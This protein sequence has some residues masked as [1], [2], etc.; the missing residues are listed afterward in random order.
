MLTQLTVSGFGCI[1][2]PIR[3]D[4]SPLG[5][6]AEHPA[7]DDHGL[8]VLPIAFLIDQN[9]HVSED[10]FSSISLFCQFIEGKLVSEYKKSFDE[11]FFEW[12]LQNTHGEYRYRLR[13]EKSDIV[14]ESLALKRCDQD[15]INV[16]FERHANDVQIMD[17]LSQELCNSLLNHKKAVLT[18]LLKSGHPQLASIRNFFNGICWIKNR[19]EFMHRKPHE[20]L[21]QTLYLLSL[22]TKSTLETSKLDRLI[23]TISHT[24][25]NPKNVQLIISTDNSAF[26]NSA[27]LRPDEI[28]IILYPRYSSP[29]CY[30][31]AEFK[32]KD[33]SKVRKNLRKAYEEGL[34]GPI[35]PNKHQDVN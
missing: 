24:K 20:S 3:L 10:L 30:S 23:E 14:E 7:R 16:I 18:E 12:Y 26:L 28:W 4:W 32:E 9:R 19:D 13:F 15:H 29:F 34:F 25:N 1:T 21:S 22:D 2:S 33:F 8:A 5:R 27:K 31:L 17:S 6:H 35:N 11:T